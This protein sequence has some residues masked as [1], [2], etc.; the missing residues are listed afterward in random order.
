MVNERH[1]YFCQTLYFQSPHLFVPVIN[2]LSL[3]TAVIPLWMR[4]YQLNAHIR[5]GGRA[6]AHAYTNKFTLSTNL[7]DSAHVDLLLYSVRVLLC[8]LHTHMGA[9]HNYRGVIYICRR[10][11]LH[12]EQK[13][14]QARR[15]TH[16]GLAKITSPGRVNVTCSRSC[17]ATLVPA[18]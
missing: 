9:Q 11:I 7:I 8:A 14:A 13:C 4:D 6:Q 15:K 1:M 17:G 2:D 3:S 18:D 10:H 12:Q 5:A 16:A